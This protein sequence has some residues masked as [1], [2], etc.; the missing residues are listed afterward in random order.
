MGK[1]GEV[2]RKSVKNVGRAAY[3]TL[4]PDAAQ[5]RRSKN[6]LVR[7]TVRAKVKGDQ[8]RAIDQA[9]AERAYL[10]QPS[11]P[12]AFARHMSLLAHSPADIAAKRA[13][14]VSPIGKLMSALNKVK[15]T[16]K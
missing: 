3:E 13:T 10:K 14:S 12:G 15:K 6:A 1:L 7:M 9:D 16:K 2:L 4:N 11:E 5:A 8:Q